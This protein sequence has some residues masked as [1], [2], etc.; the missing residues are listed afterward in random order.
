MD[1]TDGIGLPLTDDLIPKIGEF[2]ESDDGKA[3]DEILRHAIPS[4]RFHFDKFIK[5]TID[6]M[7]SDLGRDMEQIRQNVEL[8]LRNEELSEEDRKMGQLV[9][10]IMGKMQSLEAGASIDEDTARLIRDVFG[11]DIP[12][13]DESIVDFSKMVY[14]DTFKSVMQGILQR[15]MGNAQNPVLRHVYRN[16]LD[17]ERLMVKY[18]IGFYTERTNDIKNYLYISWMI[19]AYLMHAEKGIVDSLG[20]NYASMPVYSQIPDEWKVITFNYSRFA[21]DFT[22]FDAERHIYF[23]GSLRRF[24]DIVNKT[25]VDID[26]YDHLDVKDF[27]ENTVATNICFDED[28]KKYAIPEFL[29][30]VKIK[31]LISKKY[32]ERWYKSDI[33][34]NEADKIII[35]GYSFN[36]ADEQFNS[37]LRYHSANKPVVIIDTDISSVI[38]RLSKLINTP[39]EAEYSDSH[40]QGHPAKSYRNIQIINSKVNEIDLQNL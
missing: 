24:V 22:N 30:P 17:I 32:I 18:F 20:E 1:A 12:I 3:V 39:E 16:L 25:E 2:L 15:S 28:H 23:H 4:L 21:Y 36:S 29:P 35:A 34:M 33:I 26:D 19:W 8:E 5:N 38:R 6:R 13:Y 10:A 31:P 40:L 14:T 7:A 37:I 11:N 9:V 27:L